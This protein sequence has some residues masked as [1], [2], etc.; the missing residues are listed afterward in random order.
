MK[1]NS[2]IIRSSVIWMKFKDIIEADGMTITDVATKMCITQPTLSRVLNGKV[3]W[4]DKFFSRIW[5]VL[6]MSQKSISEIFKIWDNEEY[7]YN[8]WVYPWDSKEL[9]E[10]NEKEILSALYSRIWL[11]IS[12]HDKEVIDSAALNFLSNF[13]K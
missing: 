13:K 1:I 10:M 7:F 4:S 11:N 3:W 5:K 9:E 6:N 12:E 2:D 8:Y